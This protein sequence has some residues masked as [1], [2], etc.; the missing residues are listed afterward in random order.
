[1]NEE[2]FDKLMKTQTAKIL[3]GV[4]KLLE[5]QKREIF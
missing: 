3:E 2:L 4:A 1:M 5:K